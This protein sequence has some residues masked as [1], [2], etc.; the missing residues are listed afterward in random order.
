MQISIIMA[1]Y[2][3]KDTLAQAID[4]VHAQ[5]YQNIELVIQDG[6]ST[7]GSLDIIA[8][9]TDSRTSLQSAP[10]K[11]I[12]DA[13]NKGISRAHGDII[14]LLHSDD[15]LASEF[16]IG[17][18]AAAFDDPNVDGVYGDL[19]Y[20]S[21]CNTHKII[22][23]WNAGVFRAARLRWGW[24]P[25][26]PTVYLRR[27]VFDR[28]G[29]YDTRYKIAADYDAML[30]YLGKGSVRMAYLPEVLVRM[31]VGGESNRSIGRIVNKSKEDY[32]ALRANGVGGIGTLV[33]KN[34]SKLPQFL[35]K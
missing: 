22:R 18:I 15:F 32:R 13:I 29:V 19:Q 6:G 24:M 7:D 31:R 34:L 9:R 25:P 8:Q 12:Y 11:G 16:V 28:L 3:R 2:N 5:R 14:G 26:H 35:K 10:D 4:S 33:W 23:H 30:R 27:S 1:V 21:A 20:V 17:K